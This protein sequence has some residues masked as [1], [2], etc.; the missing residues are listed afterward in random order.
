MSEQ[1]D[2]HSYHI[3]IYPFK[4]E[5]N[6]C[7]IGVFSE[8]TDLNRVCELFSQSHKSEWKNETFSFLDADIIAN[9]SR[10]RFNEYNYFYDFTGNA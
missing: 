10:K 6:K 4:W 2:Y 1:T 8:K 9:F 5:L 3:F 7:K